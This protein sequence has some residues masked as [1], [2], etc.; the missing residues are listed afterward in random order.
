MALRSCNTS[1]MTEIYGSCAA[2]I[3]PPPFVL[4]QAGG[5]RRA[6]VGPGCM[7]A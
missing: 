4:Q 6:I 3:A 5:E 2:S 7:E 1:T